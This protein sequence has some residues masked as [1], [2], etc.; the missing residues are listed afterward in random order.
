[1][2]LFLLLSRSF[3]LSLLST[4]LPYYHC[5]HRVRESF[6]L[7]ILTNLP[8]DSKSRCERTYP[9]H[10]DQMIQLTR[11]QFRMEKVHGHPIKCTTDFCILIFVTIVRFVVVHLFLWISW[12]DIPSCFFSSFLFSLFFSHWLYC[13]MHTIGM[14]PNKAIKCK[15]DI[16]FAFRVSPKSLSNNVTF[17]S[18]CCSQQSQNHLKCNE[19]RITRISQIA[20]VNFVC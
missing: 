4:E 2:I 9:L 7:H 18:I 1:M 13:S 6:Y 3:A 8:D 11:I 20:N 17:L 5:G 14:E 19:T 10:S 12:V 15:I 16:F